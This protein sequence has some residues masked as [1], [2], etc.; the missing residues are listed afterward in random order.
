MTETGLIPTLAPGARLDQATKRELLAFLER[1]ARHLCARFGL[2]YRVLEAERANVK[3][4]YGVCFSDGT[5][6]IRLRHAATGRALK[7]SSLVNTLCHEL[8]HLRH[9]NHGPN[10]QALYGQILEC[11][12]RDGI[13]RPKAAVETNRPA[14]IRTAA[15]APVRA[16]KGPIRQTRPALP[17]SEGRD[18]R[19]V[20]TVSSNVR[21]E[22]PARMPAQLELFSS[23]CANAS[24][25]PRAP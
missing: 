1:D 9:F 21:L 4:R 17:K 6:R 22:R 2:R 23:F 16:P 15:S 14:E 10:F 7:Y 20:P 19:E 25:S 5:I 24:L 11:A 3:R 18:G 8:A 12:R 13:Y